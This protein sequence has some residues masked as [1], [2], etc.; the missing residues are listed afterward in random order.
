MKEKGITLI[1]LVITIIILIILSGVTLQVTIGKN[2]LIT[3]AQKQKEEQEII[4]IT[5]EL[6][7]RKAT[8]AVE[9]NGKVTIEDY[10]EYLQGN[11][12]L[13]NNEITSVEEENEENTYIIVDDKYTYLLQEE[14]NGNLLII[15]EGKAGKLK[16]RI[17]NLTVTNTTNSISVTVEAKRAKEYTFY[18]KDT[19]S[20]DYGNAQKTNETGEYKFENLNQNAEYYIKV[21]VKN[22]NG[23]VETEVTRK[24]EQ[25]T[26]AETGNLIIAA[27]TWNASSHTASTTISKAEQ[28]DSNLKI[29]YQVVTDVSNIKE[30]DWNTGTKVEN[31]NHN[32]YV[33]ARLWDGKNGGKYTSRKVTDNVN[34]SVSLTIGNITNKQVT[35]TANA[36]DNES[37][38]VS[39]EFYIEG[40]KYD[41]SNNSNSIT[42][43]TTFGAKDCYVI[44]KDKAGNSA[45]STTG[46]IEDYEIKTKEEF[47]KFR[48]SVNEGTT[49]QGKTITQTAVIDLQ[50]NEQNQW[51]PIG[52]KENQFKGNFNGW[53]N[54]I[55]NI[56]INNKNLDGVGLFGWVSDA[57]IQNIDLGTNTIIAND[58]VGGIVGVCKNSNII[59]CNN[60]SST[61][62]GNSY[63]GG[64]IGISENSNI[65]T[66]CINNGTITGYIYVGGLVG[67]NQQNGTI[68]ESVNS[69]SISSVNNGSQV[70]GIA[71]VQLEANTINSFNA[72]IIKG[73][74][75]AGGI[76]GN[77]IRGKIESCYNTKD[78]IGNNWVGGLTGSN[79]GSLMSS[80][81][82][83]NITG[84]LYVGTILGE[85][86]AS[87]SVNY[88]YTLS[89]A[90]PLNMLCGIHDEAVENSEAKSA[91]DMKKAEFVKLLNTK[92]NAWK[93]E[94]TKNSGYPI[95]NW[96]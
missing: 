6:E 91:E 82:L 25:V 75:Y 87:S 51:V 93:I 59:S 43:G 26:T 61:I 67:A 47:E 27:P 38:I 15:Y 34:P 45:T 2:G 60:Y 13:Q 19:I 11:G 80:Y 14:K 73:G 3:R 1:S 10:L 16:P 48:D 49:Y 53:H 7:I 24:T 83:G 88:C 17:V 81:T 77:N 21:E 41:N 78:I 90:T 85:N 66:R 92:K 37:G 94:S 30:S 28:I 69:G 36:Q 40:Q 9:N 84:N 68:K 95:L 64:I 18:I 29:Q 33:C 32:D 50:G 58:Y 8:V 22:E 74:D 44:V 55:Q 23:T 31:L 65:I 42:V 20:G 76:I 62:T 96:Q 35:I 5:E 71:G 54:A 89:T 56:Y 72:G 86:V 12:K 52:T 57:T 39:Y 79:S 63:V 46:I 4:I 70:G